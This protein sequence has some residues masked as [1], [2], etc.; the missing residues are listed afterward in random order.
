MNKR[1]SSVAQ[2]TFSP[3]FNFV[4]RVC[5]QAREDPAD[6]YLTDCRTINQVPNYISK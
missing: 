2:T 6:T 4:N 1:S 5:T 3:L